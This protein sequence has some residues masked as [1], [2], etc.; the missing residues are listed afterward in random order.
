MKAL[1]T[2]ATGFIGSHLTEKLLEM[3]WEVTC[4]VRDPSNLKNIKDKD[5]KTIKGDCSDINS[6]QDIPTDFDYIFHL[7]GLTKSSSSQDYY[8]ANTTGTQNIVDITLKTQQNLKRFLHLSSLAAVGP[9]K[10]NTPLNEADKPNPVS[11]YGMSKLLAEQYVFEKRNDLPVTIIRPP[12]V[13]G[14]RDRDLFVFFKMINKGIAIY[15]QDCLYSIIYIDDLINGII[16]STMSEKTLGDIFF[17]S[18]DRFY[19]QLDIIDVISTALGKKTVKV[20]LP[21]KALNLVGFLVEQLKS[22]NIIN[23]D[24]IN[25]MKQR[26][27][28]CSSNKAAETFGFGCKVTIR[29]GIQ[30]TANWY[31][32][33]NWL[34]TTK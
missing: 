32:T 21:H 5:I 9:S 22:K 10:D 20:R 24:K 14:P 30:W 7:A 2:G 27:W 11:D 28:I 3:G 13:Y 17:L 4:I 29:E 16:Q 6:L 19:S 25:E 1:I 31:I 23:T 34:Q 12:I 18:E 8:V 26:R 15:L 33:Q